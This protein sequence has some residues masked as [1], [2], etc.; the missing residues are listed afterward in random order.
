MINT[1]IVGLGNIGFKYDKMNPNKK[2]T[3]SS[4][5]FYHK[6]FKLIGA[7]EKKKNLFNQFKKLYKAPIFDSLQS[8]LQ[9][10]KPEFVIFTN[11]PNLK[12]LL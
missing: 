2:I 10:L 11:Q 8:S 4:S 5:I 12:D 1:L 7:V 3:H 6:N 9:V